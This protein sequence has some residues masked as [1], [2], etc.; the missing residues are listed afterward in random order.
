MG[1]LDHYDEDSFSENFEAKYKTKYD[2]VMHI[3][4]FLILNKYNLTP[5]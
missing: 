1:I 5:D 4:V 2:F 3:M